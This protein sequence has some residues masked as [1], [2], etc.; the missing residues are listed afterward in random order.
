M[1]GQTCSLARY[2]SFCPKGIL[3]ICAPLLTPLSYLRFLKLVEASISAG[4]P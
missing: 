2:L 3:M 1:K 4:S